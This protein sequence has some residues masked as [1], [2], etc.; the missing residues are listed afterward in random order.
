MKH[1]KV[2]ITKITDD[3]FNGNH[4]NG[5]NEGFVKEGIELKPIKIGE[6]Y[7]VGLN[8]STSIVKKLPDENG[9][10]KTNYSTYKLEY[11]EN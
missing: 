9:I 4:P 7:Y 8:F 6:R 10:F 1:L 5:I 3:V 2:R 11:L